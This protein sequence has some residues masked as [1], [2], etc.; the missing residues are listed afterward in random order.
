LILSKEKKKFNTKKRKKKKRKKKRKKKKIKKKKIYSKSR[1]VSCGFTLCWFGRMVAVVWVVW[2]VWAVWAACVASAS[3]FNPQD[4]L[5]PSQVLNHP[6]ERNF[7]S[8]SNYRL[9]ST[10]QT[11][12]MKRI[13]I[14]KEHGIIMSLGMVW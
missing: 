14:S 3:T 5:Y 8:H 4:P 2:I 10:N 7:L 9:I 11:N 1:K 13:S 12:R 6:F